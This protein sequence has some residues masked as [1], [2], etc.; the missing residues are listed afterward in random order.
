M[1]LSHKSFASVVD[2]RHSHILGAFYLTSKDLF[3]RE[4]KIIS[5]RSHTMGGLLV[6]TKAEE[7]GRLQW[8]EINFLFRLLINY[9]VNLG[10]R[11][12]TTRKRRSLYLLSLNYSQTPP[13]KHLRVFTRECLRDASDSPQRAHCSVL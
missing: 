7:R 3:S 12:E 2:R 4:K 10:A 1:A 6:R 8:Q 13:R 11:N 9:M 5:S